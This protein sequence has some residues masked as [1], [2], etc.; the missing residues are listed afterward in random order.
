MVLIFTEKFYSAL[1]NRENRESLAQKIFP[2]LWYKA[3]N[4]LLYVYVL[5]PDVMFAHTCN[6]SPILKPVDVF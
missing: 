3:I 1:E 2:C 4:I 5:W 6:R